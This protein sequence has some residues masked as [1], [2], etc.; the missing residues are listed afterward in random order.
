MP[1]TTFTRVGPAQ[2]E[3]VCKF[4]TTRFYG[5]KD[6]ISSYCSRK[7]HHADPNKQRKI[8]ERKDPQAC[9]RCKNVYPLAE[10]PTNKQGNPGLRCRDC[11]QPSPEAKRRSHLW[12]SFKMTIEDWLTLY[13]KQDGKCPICTIKLP[14]SSELTKV[15]DRTTP[16]KW[17]N[18]NTDHCHETGKV[19]GILCR[20][21]N[22]GLGSFKD[23][24]EVC[25]AAAKYLTK[26]RK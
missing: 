17:R 7:C 15:L 16:W 3:F 25:R 8:K 6:R 13:N 26:H 14:E 19:R 9:S 23:D 5:Y 11:A 10:Y 20:Q 21:C 12:N 22:M 18:W 24:P 1:K 4:C 2:I